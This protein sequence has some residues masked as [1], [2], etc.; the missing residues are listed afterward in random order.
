MN[1]LQ[2]TALLVAMLGSMV[3]T[4]PAL[5]GS[6]LDLP[7]RMPLAAARSAASVGQGARLICSNDESQVT[8]NG[9]AFPASALG[10]GVLDVVACRRFGT[11]SAPSETKAGLFGLQLE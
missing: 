6:A 1:R 8:V 9:V 3:V 10:S 4:L 7:L 11:G 5:G 2:G